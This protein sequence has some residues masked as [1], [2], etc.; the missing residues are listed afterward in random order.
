MP[1]ASLLL[2]A[3]LVLFGWTTLAWF[4]ARTTPG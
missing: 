2:A 1:A 4:G 3:L